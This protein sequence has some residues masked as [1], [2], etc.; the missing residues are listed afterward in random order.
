MTSLIT[1]TTTTAAPTSRCVT[2]ETFAMPTTKKVLTFLATSLRSTSARPRPSPA[3][4]AST[5]LPVSKWARLWWSRTSTLISTSKFPSIPG[6]VSCTRPRTR[7]SGEWRRIEAFPATFSTTVRTCLA[8]SGP[9]GA[10]QGQGTTE[11]EARRDWGLR[12]LKTWPFSIF[13]VIILPSKTLSNNKLLPP[14]LSWIGLCCKL[15]PDV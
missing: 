3:A 5:T 13:Q 12:R 10:R 11:K 7:R 4:A 6:S 9:A 15:P 8:S 2:A 14:A 1:T